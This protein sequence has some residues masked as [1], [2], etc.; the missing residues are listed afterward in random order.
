[1]AINKLRLL[2]LEQEKRKRAATFDD[3]SPLEKAVSVSEQ[4]T[5]AL[6]TGVQKLL[7]PIQA[8]EQKSREF[9]EGIT[10]R[11]GA[12]GIPAPLAA[13]AGL[14]ASAPE[15]LIKALG[16]PFKGLGKIQ[17]G[18]DI[19]GDKITDI[20]TRLGVPPTIAAGLGTA[21]TLAPDVL[22][23]VLGF[24]SA[25]KTAT[26]AAKTTGRVVK[27]SKTAVKG[28]LSAKAIGE[29]LGRAESAKG[30]TQ[31]QP[32]TSE[33][34]ERLGLPKTQR[35]FSQVVNEIERRLDAGT[36]VNVQDLADFRVLAKSAFNERA[37]AKGTQRRAFLTRAKKKVDAEFGRL[38]PER[39][40]PAR[41]LKILKSA[42]K[43]LGFGAVGV[44][45]EFGRRK[46]LKLFGGR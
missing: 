6:G 36:T 18:A 11:L 13:G 10:E 29:E 25:V 21:T 12:Q 38:V 32:I 31:L 40:D 14:A 1:M 30:V 33:L 23:S 39:I 42:Q 46:L 17:E 9:G 28:R 27:A 35:K 26:K 45:V 3:R 8:V 37:F 19:A 24:P 43:A 4:V 15:V 2:L 20:A 41:R 34:A 22:L 44:G 5:G 7:Q 16:L